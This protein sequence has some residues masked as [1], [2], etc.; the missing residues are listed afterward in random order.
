MPRSMLGAGVAA[1]DARTLR[2]RESA[3]TLLRLNMFPDGG[4]A[5]LRVYGTPVASYSRS[6]VVD[7]CRHLTA[8]GHWDAQTSTTATPESD[9][10]RQR[11]HN[12]RG[13]GDSAPPRPAVGAHGGAGRHAAGAQV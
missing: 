10:A 9:L 11:G 13:M 3:C 1:T 12:G 7:L 6:S 8:R 2:S 4:I 5:R